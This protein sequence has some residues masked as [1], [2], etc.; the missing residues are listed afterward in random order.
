M[1]P[2]CPASCSC[3]Q[4]GSATKKRAKKGTTAECMVRARVTTHIA[5]VVALHS[6][7]SKQ[8]KH[9]YG[10]DEILREVGALHPPPCISSPAGALTGAA[11][12]SAGVFSLPPRRARLNPARSPLSA[13]GVW[14]LRVWV[15]GRTLENRPWSPPL[16]PAVAT[17]AAAVLP[18]TST[19]WVQEHSRLAHRPPRDSFCFL[20]IQVPKFAMGAAYYRS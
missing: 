6:R 10:P 20:V 12:A 11:G 3:E 2:V 17:L 16:L 13:G 9:N 19:M 1:T 14:G 4:L 18:P 15:C 5:G 7:V 8:H